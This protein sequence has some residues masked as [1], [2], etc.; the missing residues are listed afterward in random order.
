MVFFWFFMEN[1]GLREHFWAKKFSQHLTHFGPQRQQKRENPDFRQKSLLVENPRRRKIH[2]LG[3]GWS[4]KFW[5]ALKIPQS[6]SKKIFRVLTSFLAPTPLL[7]IANMDFRRKTAIFAKTLKF[8]CVCR[9]KI[10]ISE[11]GIFGDDP[12]CTFLHLTKNLTL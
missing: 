1:N 10:V 2:L 6:V 9:S 11:R 8:G 12:K 3:A 4:K 5:P 7:E